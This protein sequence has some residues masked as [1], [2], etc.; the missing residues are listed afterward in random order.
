MGTGKYV[1]VVIWPDPVSL[2]LLLVVKPHLLAVV[3]SL[4]EEKV[5]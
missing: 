2:P 1:P 5:E 3:V 4:V